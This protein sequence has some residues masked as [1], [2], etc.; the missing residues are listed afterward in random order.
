MK[1][2]LKSKT[3]IGA[4]IAVLP[5]LG[6]LLG[7]GIDDQVLVNEAWDALQTIAGA[8]LS[9]YGRFKAEDKLSFNIKQ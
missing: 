4:I 9:V 3:V 2:F 5:T 6:P 1:F 8:V 7:F